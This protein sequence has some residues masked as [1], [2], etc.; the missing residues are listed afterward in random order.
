MRATLRRTLDIALVAVAVAVF[1]AATTLAAGSLDLSPWRAAMAV[2]AAAALAGLA[3][4]EAVS[5]ELQSWWGRHTLAPALATSIPLLALTALVVEAALE[6][7]LAAAEERRWQLAARV[8]CEALL[9]QAADA[10]RPLRNFVVRTSRQLGWPAWTA[11][12]RRRR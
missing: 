9:V 10:M 12:C 3:A 11:R 4:S 8:A 5:P 7:T 6:R 1:A 2:V